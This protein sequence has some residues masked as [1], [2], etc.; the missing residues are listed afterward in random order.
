MHKRTKVLAEKDVEIK[1]QQLKIE[2]LS[3]KIIDPG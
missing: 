1:E 2:N 3:K